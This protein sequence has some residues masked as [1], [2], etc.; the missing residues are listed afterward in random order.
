MKE[1]NFVTGIE[2]ESSSC[3]E[4]RK[5]SAEEQEIGKGKGIPYAAELFQK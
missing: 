3:K 1:S 5:G 2:S 4:K